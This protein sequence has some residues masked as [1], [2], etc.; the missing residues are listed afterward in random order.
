MMLPTAHG[1]PPFECLSAMQK[2]IRRSAEKEAMEF[3]V[4]LMHT[5]KAYNTLVAN[6]LEI[7]SHED[8]DTMAAP[9]IVALVRVCCEQARS[10][11]DDTKG[12]PGKSRMAIG[13]AIRAMCRAPKSREGDHFQAAIGLRSLL[14]SYV[15]EIPDWAL[16]QHTARG[17]RMGRGLEHFFSEATKLVPPP[18]EPDPYQAEAHRL[19]RLKAR[20]KARGEVAVWHGNQGGDDAPELDLPSPDSATTPAKKPRSADRHKEPNRDRHSEGYMMAYMRR[21]RADKEGS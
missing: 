12:N 3:A 9:H 15:P 19:W 16:D 21:R 4:E 14:E 6:R 20:T 17:K 2:C 11:Y 5:S 13:T 8:I 1:L 18:D 10:W 7:V